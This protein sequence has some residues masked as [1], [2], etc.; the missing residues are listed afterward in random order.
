VPALHIFVIALLTLAIRTS[1]GL[2]RMK[3]ED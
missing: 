3:N 1:S 2:G